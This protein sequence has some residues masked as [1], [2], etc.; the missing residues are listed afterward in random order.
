M[1]LFGDKLLESQFKD[2][3]A[4]RRAQHFYIPTRHGLLQNFRALN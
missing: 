3:F 2:F 4:V 1:S